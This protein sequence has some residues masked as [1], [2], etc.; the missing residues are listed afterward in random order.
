[1]AKKKYL[2]VLVNLRFFDFEGGFWGLVDKEGREW[3]PINLTDEWTSK[4]DIKVMVS[5]L[6]N[7]AVV[8]LVNWGTPVEIIEIKNA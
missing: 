1:M 7:E 3:L 2:N 4:G 6:V 8:S 5:F